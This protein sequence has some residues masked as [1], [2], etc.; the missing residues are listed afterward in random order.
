MKHHDHNYEERKRSESGS[1]EEE[2][3]EKQP[4]E[5]E[6]HYCLPPF[7][8][9]ITNPPGG[10]GSGGGGLV[11]TLLHTAQLQEWEAFRQEI[12]EARAIANERE[13]RLAAMKQMEETRSRDLEAMETKLRELQHELDEA[14][15][16]AA[17][18]DANGPSFSSSFLI[19]TGQHVK[20]IQALQ[21]QVQALTTSFLPQL[22]A[23]MST[24][25]A[26]DAADTKCA[27]ALS[28]FPSAST[29]QQKPAKKSSGS[30]L[31][32]KI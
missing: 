7:L 19:F 13:V 21:G 14:R 5:K 28:T 18:P 4:H 24:L 25:T 1:D 29:K 26:R 32:L 27:P 2:E 9:Q 10:S 16:A 8:Y 12:A 6:E 17:A 11:A 15:K 31:S 3:E 30:A 23:R 22:E 20:Q